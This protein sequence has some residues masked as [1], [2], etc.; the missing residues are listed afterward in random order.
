MKPLKANYL[1]A[2]A[3][4]EAWAAATERDTP[5]ETHFQICSQFWQLDQD[6]VLAPYAD[7]YLDVVDAIGSGRGTGA[8]ASTTIRQHVLGLLFPRP[9][10]DRAFIA[11]L[12]G[13]LE[14]RQLPDSVR[15]LVSERRDDAVRA[16]NNQER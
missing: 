10:A 9:L 13:F 15:R 11:K 1:G 2:A 7:L 5:N 14:G 8:T 12:D 6:E 3:K 16:L 4:A